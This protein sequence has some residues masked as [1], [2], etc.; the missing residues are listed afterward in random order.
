[1]S[2]AWKSVIKEP[3]WYKVISPEEF[4]RPGFVCS[5]MQSI[6]SY[7]EKRSWDKHSCKKRML[8]S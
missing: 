3:G 2:E 7:L 1:M 4:I 5:E 8:E 6:K